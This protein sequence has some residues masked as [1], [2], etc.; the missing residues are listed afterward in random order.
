[1]RHL[2]FHP[3]KGGIRESDVYITCYHLLC[4]DPTRILH[5]ESVHPDAKDRHSHLHLCPV[6]VHLTLPSADVHIRP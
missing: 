6:V 2:S 4:P 3:A 5:F 1:M